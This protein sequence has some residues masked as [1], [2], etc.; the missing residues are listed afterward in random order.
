MLE[1]EFKHMDCD[2]CGG[3]IETMDLVFERERPET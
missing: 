3:F 1:Y 2:E